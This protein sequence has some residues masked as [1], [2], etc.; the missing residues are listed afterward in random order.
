MWYTRLCR[1]CARKNNNRSGCGGDSMTLHRERIIW[2][3]NWGG[4]EG[5]GGEDTNWSE[6]ESEGWGGSGAGLG[7]F[8][9]SNVFQQ[10]GIYRCGDFWKDIYAF[11]N[12][13]P[14][15]P[16]WNNRREQKNQNTTALGQKQL[17]NLVGLGKILTT[18]IRLTTP[19]FVLLWSNGNWES[20]K[21]LQNVFCIMY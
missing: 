16:I 13:F 1:G 20:S 14:Y 21:V 9:P 3:V 2:L 10:F 15:L 4:R 17:Q 5:K 11:F 6:T 12:L 8:F 19:A 7:V 18:I